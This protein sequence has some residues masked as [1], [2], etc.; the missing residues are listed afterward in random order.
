M[1]EGD[2]N[3]RG[4][5]A[6][7]S[8]RHFYDMLS[9]IGSE[10]NLTNR[11]M[12]VTGYLEGFRGTLCS[13]NM[14]ELSE[15]FPRD[16]HCYIR[17]GFIIHLIFTLADMARSRGDTNLADDLRSRAGMFSLPNQ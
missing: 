2:A 4:A 6:V 7:G 5:D 13:L 11:V 8:I 9:L 3:D 1:D 15:S 16:G 17:A 10:T 14:R 12:I